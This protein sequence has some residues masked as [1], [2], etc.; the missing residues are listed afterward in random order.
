M[1]VII[2]KD[3]TRT[4]KSI[5]KVAIANKEE[6]E[7]FLSTQINLRGDGF[8]GVLYFPLVFEDFE[9]EE[10]LEWC[11]GEKYSRAD[12]LAIVRHFASLKFDGEEDTLM[13][14]ENIEEF[15]NWKVEELE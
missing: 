13:E 9:D 14:S 8:L 5:S 3:F 10:Y 12:L 11:M 4:L 2:N 15:H 7:L 1:Q 6:N